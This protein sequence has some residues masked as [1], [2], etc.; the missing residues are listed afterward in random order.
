VAKGQ[1]RIRCQERLLAAAQH[2]A[3]TGQWG[4][5]KIEIP[6]TDGK[7][8]P[9]KGSPAADKAAPAAEKPAPEKQAA[10]AAK[11]AAT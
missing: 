3:R 9:E 5:I 2:L 11:P 7:P 6:P 4:N 1:P 8:A 10:P